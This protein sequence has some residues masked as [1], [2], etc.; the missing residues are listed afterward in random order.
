MYYIGHCLLNFLV[1]EIKL[2]AFKMSFRE[3]GSSVGIVTGYGLDSPGI[4]SWRGRDFPPVQT[5][6]WAQPAS[7]KMGTRSLS[8]VELTG[9]WGSP[10]TPI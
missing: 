1:I 2:M 9:T 10:S 4:E 8:G 6:P 3:P 5:R 7:C